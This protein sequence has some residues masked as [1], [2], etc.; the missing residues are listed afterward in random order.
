MFTPAD[1]RRTRDHA[2]SN[3]ETLLL[4]VSSRLIVLK[5]HPS[6]PSPDLAPERDALNCIRVLTRLL[7][8]VYEAEHLEDWEEKFFWTGRKRRTRKAQIT[9]EILFDEGQPDDQQERPSDEEEYED[10]KPLAEEL[11]DTLLDLLFFAEFTI[12]IL[13]TAKSKVSHSIWQSGV[14]CNTAMSTSKTFESNRCEILRL[15]LTITGKAMYLPSSEYPICSCEISG[16]NNYC[17]YLAC[18]RCQSNHLHNDL[19]GQAVCPHS[20]VLSTQ[21]GMCLP[22]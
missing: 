3:F 12:P 17:R 5:N 1:I 15:L 18:T 22:N 2:L 8:Y 10:V 6:F 11:I 14:G 21:H 19:P 16:S 7:P 20:T 4:S 9:G 13:P